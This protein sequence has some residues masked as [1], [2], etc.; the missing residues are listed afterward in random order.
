MHWVSLAWQHIQKKFNGNFFPNKPDWFVDEPIIIWNSILKLRHQS[1]QLDEVSLN[2]RFSLVCVFV[3]TLFLFMFTI[4]WVFV[5]GVWLD[6]EGLWTPSSYRAREKKTPTI[7]A[8]RM[9][10]KLQ[11]A[12]LLENFTWVQWREWNEMKKKQEKIKIE[13][14][15]LWLEASYFVRCMNLNN[16]PFLLFRVFR[17]VS[18]LHKNNNVKRAIHLDIFFASVAFCHLLS[19]VCICMLLF[20]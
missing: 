15:A 8:L 9:K 10:N 18:S 19:V 3:Y 2:C 16:S 11:I 20:R 6:I 13:I 4:A 1:N 17:F 5:F 7:H 12:D 14:C